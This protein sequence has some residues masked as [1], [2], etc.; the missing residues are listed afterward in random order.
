MNYIRY[1]F[2]Y[3]KLET[4]EQNLENEG[5]AYVHI[6][7][8]LYTHTTCALMYLCVIPLITYL[9]QHLK[10][11]MMNVF[12]DHLK[13]STQDNLRIGIH[14]VTCRGIYYAQC[15]PTGWSLG[16]FLSDVTR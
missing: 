12:G 2:F 3:K 13:S 5:N 16:I 1:V 11:Q 14:L 9:D 15:C 6:Y 8:E 4:N 10:Q 7:C